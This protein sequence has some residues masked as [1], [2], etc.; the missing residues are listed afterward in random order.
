MILSP[1]GHEQVT[2]LSSVKGL[3]VPKGAQRA[4]LVCTD[5]NV[6]WRDDGTNPASDTGIQLT[7]GTLFWYS[8]DLSA[9]KFIEEAG[10]A[11]LEVSYYT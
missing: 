10:S 8:G 9:I 2:G 7:T 3:T 6:R 1:L 4:L 5:Q 11:V